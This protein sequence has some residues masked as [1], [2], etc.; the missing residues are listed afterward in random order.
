MSVDITGGSSAPSAM[1]FDQRVAVLHHPDLRDD[2]GDDSVE[3]A[4]SKMLNRTANTP[5]GSGWLRETEPE[6]RAKGP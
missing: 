6:L 1:C 5:I 4:M 3:S 2:A